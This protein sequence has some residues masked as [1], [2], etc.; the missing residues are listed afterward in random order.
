MVTLRRK[1]LR[2]LWQMRAQVGAVALIA[3]A[4]VATFVMMRGAYESLVAA[5]AGYFASSRFA[6]VFASLER[7]PEGVAGRL[8]AID[9]V[10]VVETR[11]ARNVTL[12]V[13]NLS[14]P[15]SALLLSL[16]DRG[17]PLLNAVHV[18][19]GRD[20][21]R[22]GEV[23]VSEAFAAANQLG[24]GD[25]LN[26]VINGKWRALRICGVAITPEYVQEARGTGFPDHHRF[27]ILWMLRDEVAGA[28][29]MRGAFNDV[30]M[31]LVPGA[32][33][34]GVIAAADRILAPYGGRGAYGRE[35]QGSYRF[36]RDE[37]AQ[38]RI[39]AVVIPAI[40]LAVAALLIHLLLSR[41]VTAQREQI[42]VLKAFGYGDAA[43]ARHYAGFAAAIVAAGAAAGIPAGVYFGRG[44]TA[45]YKNF[46]HFPALDFRVSA[47]SIAVSIGVTL[48]AAL[49]GSMLAVRR[50]I[51]LPPAEGMRG[52]TPA[53]FGASA[54]DRSR[55]FRLAS[56]PVRM[57]LRSLQRTPLRTLGSLLAMS[58]AAMI[59]VVGQ[60]SFDALDFMIDQTFRR[61]QTDDATVDFVDVRGEEA[62]RALQRLPGVTLVEPVR[63]VPVRMT[64]GHRARRVVLVGLERGATLRRLVGMHGEVT[65]LPPAGIV[66]TTKL[67]RTLGVGAGDVVDVE[68]LV[69]PRS[70]A[71]MQ[72][73][74]LT[75]E[76]VGLAA[77][78]PRDAVNRFLREGPS[79]TGAALAVEP[80]R[81]AALYATLKSTPA[82]A[83]VSLREAMLQSFSE[84]IAENMRIMSTTIVLCAWVIAFA[85]IY[86]GARIALSE[87]GRD[88]A[89]LRV[90]G[91]SSGEVGAMLI[92]EQAILTIASIPIG[93]AGGWLLC[94]W[95]VRLLESELYRLPFVI[96]GRTYALTFLIVAVAAIFTAAVVQRRIGRLDLVEV[97]KTRE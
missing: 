68:A 42:A 55:L 10:A 7:A 19:R 97:L 77:Y 88:L 24:P 91:F 43:V 18:R 22:A 44:L 6:H 46:F 74:A 32:D 71:P 36:L 13:P 20:V 25:A 96:S 1:L 28:S 94:L 21:A 67:A 30:A 86:N 82:V 40:F 45:M 37:I 38:D 90:L 60:Y 70:A 64:S 81:A 23:L 5:R 16:P 31:T 26:A 66:L 95:L 89:S 85:V 93:F 59:L 41:L 62:R 35:E 58:S 57:I 52:E 83:A 54:L 72:V 2:D 39:T 12:D 8:R 69:A 76:M 63:A 92:G 29:G 87:R 73:T 53:R 9:G 11:V 61:A 3:A 50:A 78:A 48:V 51:A 33:E 84:T 75:D 49:A 80:S 56:P 79:L 34:A 14:E 15:A 65:E 4:A 17:A 47:F 27:G